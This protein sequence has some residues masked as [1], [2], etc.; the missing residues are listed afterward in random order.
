[1]EDNL[2]A[3]LRAQDRAESLAQSTAAAQKSLDLAVL[4][5]QAGLTDF[6]TVLI[7]QRALLN[8]Q[9]KLAGTL[10]NIS[11]SLVGIYRALGG[12]WEIREGKDLVPGD[13]KEE[14]AKRTAWGKLL[15]SES[16]NLPSAEE[17][18]AL[19]RAPDW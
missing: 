1:V 12:G 13:I 9:D 6:T 18:K 3:F 15:T 5:Y 19:I 10:G 16:L 17:S 2:A 4:L 7:S 11:S 14:M 8:E